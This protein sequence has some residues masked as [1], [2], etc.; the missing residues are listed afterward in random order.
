MKRTLSVFLPL[1]IAYGVTLGWLYESWNW[2]DAYYAHAP[3][4]LAF[5]AAVVVRWRRRWGAIDARWDGRG[6]LLLGPGLFLHLIGAALMVDSLSGMSLI[7]TVPGAVWVALGSG[8]LRALAPVLGLL[9]FVV[10]LPIAIQGTLAFQLKEFA[11]SAGL[12]LANGL[13]AE[14]QRVGTEIRFSGMSG[15]LVVADPCSGLRSMVA[16]VT[17]G[18]CVAFFL[19]RRSGARPWIVL[20][21]AA[22]IAVGTNI[23]RIAAICW[24]ARHVSI[25]FASGRGHDIASVAIWVVD[26]GMLLALDA[27]LTRRGRR[28][29]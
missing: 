16:L 26:L 19:G 18:Y 23:L 22:P 27:W 20:A 5:A 9:P 6:W 2:G 1:A 10:P 21:A 4:V 29:R 7:L 8:R 3:L 14:A 11:I 24:I 13:G 12:T 15:A 25:E 17:L 28:A